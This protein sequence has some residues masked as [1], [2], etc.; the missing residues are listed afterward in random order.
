ML[1]KKVKP[2]HMRS[3]NQ[4][5]I[6]ITLYALRDR[7]DFSEASEDPL[8]LNPVAVLAI[9]IPTRDDIKEMM[10]NVGSPDCSSTDPIV[11]ILS[12]AFF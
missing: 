3:D 2:H 7:V 9:L 4:S 1:I 10:S 6:F 11:P 8:N 12:E 5:R